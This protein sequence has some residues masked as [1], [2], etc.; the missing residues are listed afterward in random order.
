M[1]GAGWKVSDREKAQRF[2]GPAQRST[3]YGS[4]GMP[5]TGKQARSPW[6][7][8]WLCLWPAVIQ[9]GTYKEERR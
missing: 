6:L 8:L 9:A 2:I 1:C 5:R 4:M 3:A 7:W